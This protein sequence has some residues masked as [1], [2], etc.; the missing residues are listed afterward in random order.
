MDI[1][2]QEKCFEASV[3]NLSSRW[4]I[5][6]SMVK[7]FTIPDKTRSFDLVGPS[8]VH[9]TYNPSDFSFLY[10]LVGSSLSIDRCMQ[11]SKNFW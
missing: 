3:F 10:I 9:G 2:E 7:C 11:T 8:D 1:Q 6:Q 4:Q 5:E